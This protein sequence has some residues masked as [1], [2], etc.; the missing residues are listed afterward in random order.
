MFPWV[1]FFWN[2]KDS[3]FK[4]DSDRKWSWTGSWTRQWRASL[5]MMF[6]LRVEMRGK[7]VEGNHVT[8]FAVQWALESS[9]E[10]D[11]RDRQGARRSLR[12]LAVSGIRETPM[13]QNS[14][15]LWCPGLQGEQQTV[16]DV[17]N[18]AVCRGP[19][20]ARQASYSWL[21]YLVGFSVADR[22]MQ[23]VVGQFQEY[24]SYQYLSYQYPALQCYLFWTKFQ[25]CAKP[26]TC[27]LK[28]EW[29]ITVNYFSG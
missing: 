26:I 6:I 4:K 17:G 13:T 21:E 24:L 15:G 3:Q 27:F 25:S 16:R 22:V 9:E 2:L 11:G 12:K 8:G 14:Q 20:Q 5:T 7:C 28:T 19:R 1:L 18:R 10:N 29:K 23:T